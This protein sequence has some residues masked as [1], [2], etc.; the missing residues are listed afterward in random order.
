M[1]RLMH[2]QGS[3]DKHSRTETNGFIDFC[4]ESTKL[5]N[6]NKSTSVVLLIAFF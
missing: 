2:S 3:G 6:W 4:F 5:L 1:S